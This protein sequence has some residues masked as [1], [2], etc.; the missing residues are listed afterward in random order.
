MIIAN[1]IE[2]FSQVGVREEG[3]VR[4]DPVAEVVRVDDGKPDEPHHELEMPNP[5]LFVVLQPR[6]R[7]F[8][9]GLFRRHGDVV[10]A[11]DL[12]QF[13]GG[14][15]RE[16]LLPA[17]RRELAVDD[18]LGL[19]GQHLALVSLGEEVH[20]HAV[21]H[22]HVVHHEVGAPVAERNQL[23]E[24]R[25]RQQA[26]DGVLRQQDLTRVDVVQNQRHRLGVDVLQSDLLLVALGHVVGEHG[27]EVRAGDRQDVLVAGEFLFVHADCDVDEFLVDV[28]FR[29]SSQKTGCPVLV[30]ELVVFDAGV[31]L[32]DLGYV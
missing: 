17:D 19:R 22:R 5:V 32:A 7:R 14:Q 4:V 21:A 24:V 12:D 30:N 13:V 2:R 25:R 20:A 26:L 28:K 15:G 6:Q 27:H 23:E 18:F 31:D 3:H 10:I 8:V 16:L 9:N 11:D 29:E 1:Q